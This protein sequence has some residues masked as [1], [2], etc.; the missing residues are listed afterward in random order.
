MDSTS[1]PLVSALARIARERS[2]ATDGTR[3]F[4]DTQRVSDS[5]AKVGY[6]LRAAG[7]GIR[8]SF[9]SGA[10]SSS[11]AGSITGAVRSATG[12]AVV[13]LVWNLISS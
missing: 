2:V 3:G 10:K 11:F 5:G 7:R 6:V 4:I 12:C 9:H 8:F 1:E 13:A